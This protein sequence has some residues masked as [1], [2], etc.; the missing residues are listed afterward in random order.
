MSI[1][2]QS[3]PLMRKMLGNLAAWL[4]EARSYAEERGFEVDVLVQ[5]RLH[6]DQFTLARQVESACDALTAARLA[7][8]EVPKHEDGATTV[9][10]LEARIAEVREILAG[11]TEE[12]LAGAAER[13]ITLGFL[14][15]GTF[16]IGA[17]Y[18]HDFALP[19]FF[20]HLNHAY[21]ILR[22]NGVKLGKRPYIGSMNVQSR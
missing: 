15:E 3:V 22:H 20:F 16:V 11:I 2:P 13:E 12:Q 1:Y 7:A 9:A 5:A 21:A 19:N 6:P 10:A 8:L 18:L 4:Q 17:D 14:P